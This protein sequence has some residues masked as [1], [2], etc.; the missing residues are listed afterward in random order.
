MDLTPAEKM[1]SKT[2]EMKEVKKVVQMATMKGGQTV[3]KWD[4][5]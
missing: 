1:E 3:A 2:V 4:C 5:Y